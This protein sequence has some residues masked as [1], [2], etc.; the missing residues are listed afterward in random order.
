MLKQIILKIDIETTIA[1]FKVA[2][3]KN[4]MDYN[5]TRMYFSKLQATIAK[6]ECKDFYQ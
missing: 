4:Y 2:K 3:T 6:Q 5:I 1:N